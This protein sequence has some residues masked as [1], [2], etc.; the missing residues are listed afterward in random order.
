MRLAEQRSISTTSF[1]AHDSRPHKVV[2]ALS[3]GVD[4]SVAA[5][6][7]VKKAPSKELVSAVHMSNWNV[8][9]HDD[10]TLRSCS[11]ED[12]WEDALA[13]AKH[14]N[15]SDFRRIRFEKDY[16]NMVFQ[17]YIDDI[18]QHNRMGNPDI[19]CN[20][21]IKFGSLQQ[22]IASKQPIKGDGQKIWL[23][24]GHYARLW[25][26]HENPDTLPQVVETMLGDVES[27]SMSPATSSLARWMRWLQS[28]GSTTETVAPKTIL[29]AAADKTKDQSYFLAGCSSRSLSNVLFPLGE[30]YKTRRSDG[31][32]MDSQD[33][34]KPTIKTVREMAVDFTLPTATKRESMGICFVGKRRN[35][36]EFLQ[37][38]LPPPRS[39]LTFVD[40]DTGSVV[41]SIPLTGG[42]APSIPP[43]AC[44][45]TIGQGAKISGSK[46]K[47]F[48]VD[49][50]LRSNQVLVCAGTHH[51]A[52]Y[53]QSFTFDMKWMFAHSN[54]DD[55]ALMDMVTNVM[56][57]L[58]TVDESEGPCYTMRVQCR[59]RHLQPL[60]DGTLI[61]RPL[62][63]TYTIELDKPVRGVT[64]G[65]MT[66]LYLG[67]LICL[68]G[69][70]IDQRGPTFLELNR[71]LPADLYPSG[72]N[73]LSLSENSP[74]RSH[75]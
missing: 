56:D 34:K 14:L 63:N 68:G 37:D 16:W 32:L 29:L 8:T 74:V 40:V 17:P 15:I 62:S 24:T 7:I 61:Y 30:Y 64:P 72:H 4:S 55:D 42:R 3:G 1:I 43:H 45:Y 54:N 65:Q 75:S 27:S 12:D 38:Y 23:A 31:S 47:Y 60:M 13:V 2:V 19:G 46:Q 59:I 48:V 11:S 66:V 50:D 5:A 36:R 35:F 41:G 22:Y 20:V 44:L 71:L 28:S 26:R 39:D 70:P 6:L 73:D 49:T 51:P 9:S 25:H 52:L 69:G 33:A 58:N 10:D 18:V 67:D 21:H 53:T 57:K